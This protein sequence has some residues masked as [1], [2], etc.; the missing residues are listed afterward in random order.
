MFEKNL[1]END[2]AKE[3]FI[4][5]RKLKAI[6]KIWLFDIMLIALIPPICCFMRYIV[7]YDPSEI[8]TIEK[9]WNE[10]NEFDTRFLSLALII[11]F[12]FGSFIATI[13]SLCDRKKYEAEYE[14]LQK[15]QKKEQNTKTVDQF[16]STKRAV[17]LVTPKAYGNYFISIQN[18]YEA[19]LF[20]VLQ[21]STNKVEIFIKHKG[22]EEEISFEEIS[23]ENFLNAYELVNEN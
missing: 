11:V 15:E 19:Q 17:R 14:N 3:K 16:L 5:K 8:M 1:S 9:I 6:C 20:A 23:K 4:K 22:I 21:E 7:F 13:S 12:L 2:N 18:D 10:W